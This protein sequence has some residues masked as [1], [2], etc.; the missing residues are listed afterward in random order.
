ME[1]SDRGARSHALSKDDYDEEGR[2]EY[3]RDDFIVNNDGGEPGVF[4][5]KTSTSRVILSV[6]AV[7]DDEE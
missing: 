5:R 6:M 7:R 3:T 4:A 2:G 1:E